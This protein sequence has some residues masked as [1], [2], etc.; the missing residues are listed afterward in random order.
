MR[1]KTQETLGG[2]LLILGIPVFAIFL[3]LANAL[4]KTTGVSEPL[5]ILVIVAVGV[6]GGWFFFLAENWFSSLAEKRKLRALQIENIDWMDGV[7]FQEYLQKL[8]ASQG[9]SVSL[10]RATGDSG[11]DLIASHG[12]DRIA[13][14]VK[15]HSA[16]VSRRAIS[17]AVGGMRLYSCNQAMVIT[18]N[19]F[20][21]GA[22][23]LARSNDCILVDRD[24]LI[25]WVLRFRAG[26]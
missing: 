3:Y 7:Q 13:I 23:L 21:P 10:T 8:L 19:Y 18:N 16:K 22:I 17:D 15:R 24:L 4:K 26:K 9:Y 12:K 6:Y 25:Q 11:V 14:Q 20:T 5:I 2:I 1:N